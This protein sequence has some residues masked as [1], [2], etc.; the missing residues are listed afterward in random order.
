MPKGGIGQGAVAN[1]IGILK[2][3]IVAD[4]FRKLP[5]RSHVFMPSAGVLR[6]FEGPGRKSADV[7]HLLVFA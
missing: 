7:A 3:R 1:G 5:L 6:V 4:E 2:G